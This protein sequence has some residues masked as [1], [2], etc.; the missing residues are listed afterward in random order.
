MRTVAMGALVDAVGCEELGRTGMLDVSE[1]SEACHCAER[2]VLGCMM[3]LCRAEFPA[4]GEALVCCSE[5]KQLLGKSGFGQ[6]VP[7]GHPSD[8]GEVIWR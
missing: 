6:R 5:K 3:G 4:E 1:C 7:H 2:Y 8:V